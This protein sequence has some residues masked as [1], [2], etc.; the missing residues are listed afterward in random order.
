VEGVVWLISDRS[1][2]QLVRA[3]LAG[4]REAFNVLV[5]R[6][7]RKVYSYLVYL[8]GHAEDA[9]DLCQEAFV[10]AY[11]HLGRLR[12]PERFSSWLFQIA[13]N[14]AYSHL[15]VTREREA[16]LDE[17]RLAEFPE[18]RLGNGPALGPGELK[19]LVEKALGA[20]PMEQREAVVLKF[21]QGFKFAEIAEIQNCPVSTAKT[22]VYA[23]LEQLKKI[24]QA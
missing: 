9:W 14:T 11:R 20:L 18:T 3:A 2:A 22:R 17:P 15:R 5:R 16:E 6:W 12:E 1:D 24:L 13:H 8:T 21:Y 23:S 7:E 19:L 10:S 4:E